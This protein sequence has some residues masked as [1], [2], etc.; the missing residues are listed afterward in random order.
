MFR[1][2]F[3]IFEGTW[4]F[5]RLV[6]PAPCGVQ[7]SKPE[8]LPVECFSNSHLKIQERQ[9]LPSNPTAWSGP[10]CDGTTAG[11][12]GSSKRRIQASRAHQ[13][14][15][16]G[17]MAPLTNDARSERQEYGDLGH[18]GRLTGAAERR[19]LEQLWTPR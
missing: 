14:P 13:P 9:P 8:L 17:M 16:T 1:D 2:E 6:A 18:L 12:T 11:T 3:A 7:S 5:A 4:R 19:L 15:S 10:R